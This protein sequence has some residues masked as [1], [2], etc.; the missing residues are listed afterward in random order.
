MSKDLKSTP[1]K[2]VKKELQKVVPDLDLQ[3][4]LTFGIIINFGLAILIWLSIFDLAGNFGG[5]VSSVLYLLFGM[6]TI[7]LPIINFYIAIIM[8]KIQRNLE[9][10]GEIN[11]RM[12]WGIFLIIW[13]VTGFL[14][15]INNTLSVDVV[16]KS[17][18][19]LGYI[20]YPLILEP[21]GIASYLLIFL[22]FFIGFFLFSQLTFVDFID[23]SKKILKE[24]KI[25]LDIIPDIFDIWKSKPANKN[26][27][28]PFFIQK[29][30]NITEALKVKNTLKA[31][32]TDPEPKLPLNNTRVALASRR[33]LQW[34]LPR[35]EL[36][37]PIKLKADAGDI[38][39]NKE[40]IQKTL[41]N[42]GIE[43]EMDYTVTGPTV[44]QY[45]FKPASGI[46]LS[47]IDSLQRDIALSLAVNSLRIESPVGGRS[48][49]G[50]EIPNKVK[51]AV[52]LR[53]ILQSNA[54]VN[55]ED[56]LPVSIGQDVAGKNLVFSL[57][58]MPHLLVA[59]ATGS[60]KSI[61]INSLL[62]S[63]LYR[64]S[65]ED[66]EL[67]LV[68]MKRVE[69]KLYE[70]TPHLLSPVITDAE[71]AINAL[72]WA[73][74]EMDK[75]YRVLEEQGKR[76]IADY[77]HFAE[78]NS[79]LELAKMTYQVIVIDELGDLMMLA[80]SE[81]E[82]I[83][84]RLTQMSRAVGIH[85]VLGTQ[86]PDTNV[87]TGLIKANV[88][89]RIAFAVA[90]QIDSR[91]VLDSAGAEKLLGQGD[92]L[93]MTSTSPRPVRFQGALITES[94][95]KKCVR[96]LHEQA[97]NLEI[98]TNFNPSV[99]EPPKIQMNFPGAAMD[100]SSKYDEVYEQSKKLI[101]QYQKASTSFLQQMLGIGYPK[102]AKI[103][104]LLEDDGLVGPANGSK[105]RDIYITQEEL[106]Q[107]ET[108]I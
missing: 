28:N 16:S 85:L 102:A 68:D 74:L 56:P 61:W 95:I 62:I 25:I 27:K 82:P 29:I 32:P 42:F 67:I 30:G 17:G 50:L 84:V 103:M 3:T 87:V 33:E 83:I 35:F 19:L 73:V 22:I 101:V 9:L 1:W 20:L 93:F 7:F 47:S 59:G 39:G 40:K 79:E 26:P 100:P 54:F 65:P 107:V 55:F 34:E 38:E 108:Q 75:R 72:K 89:S 48:L 76:N 2:S 18:G 77:N 91:V 97:I 63:L 71:D 46:K 88:P 10:F 58:K 53:S 60:G 21:L 37:D 69:L 15:N 24:P 90:S 11:L 36:L 14:S 78:T 49:V 6:I 106:N 92:G 81:V 52:G 43:V 51:S 44:T 104:Q 86:R 94:E 23:K 64:Y 13:S 5:M 66:L 70:H 8:M 96:F 105:S 45:T 12:S 99:T 41:K 4:K 98:K 31:T 80:K 57:A